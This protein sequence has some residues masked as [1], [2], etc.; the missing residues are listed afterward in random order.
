MVLSSIG[1]LD[2]NYFLYFEE[3]DFC[4][5][6]RQAGFD[7]WYVPASRV[8]HIMGQ[9]TLVTDP[10]LGLRRLPGYW[11]ESRR[12]YFVVTHGMWKAAL[13]DVVAV[14]A[15]LVGNAKSIMLRRKTVPHYVR[16]L[17][18]HSVIWSRNRHV[19]ELRCFFP[20]V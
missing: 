10:A 6:A 7:T 11:F 18:H 4:F 13:I 3:T 17:V 9:S 5:R 8:M 20:A 16:D 12:R 15:Q 14:L 2:E 19:A 1:G